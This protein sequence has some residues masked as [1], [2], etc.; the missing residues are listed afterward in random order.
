MTIAAVV[1]A[2]GQGTRFG[3]QKQ[4]FA[5]GSETV[6]GVAV[7]LARSVAHH[8]VLVVPSDYLGDGEGADDVVV[9]GDSRS[10][11]VKAGLAKCAGHDI[12]LVH[13][14]ARP[15]ATADLFRSV[16]LAVREGAD[17]AVPGL[18]LA[19]T[20][21][22]VRHDHGVTVVAGTLDRSTL[23]RVQ[24]PQAF[25]SEILVKAHAKGQE[26]SDD[27][28]LV[29]LIGGR[30]VVVPGEEG[31]HKLTEPGDAALLEKGLP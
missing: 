1:V 18:A 20:I 2:A 21:K 5:L 10:A 25:R 19:D 11:S 29:E 28:A 17:G 15:F 9:G 7:R 3:G 23:V 14:A 27:A 30:I 22:T 4:F 8:V 26:A 16:V 12:V 24:T 6:A 13:D 31:N